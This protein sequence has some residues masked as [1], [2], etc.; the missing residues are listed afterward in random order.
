MNI[1]ALNTTNKL[2]EV[3]CS[4]NGKTSSSKMDGAFSEHIIPAIVDALER[5]D[6]TLEQIDCMGVVV[7]P[8]SFTGI[9]IG[10][11]VLKGIVCAEP[12]KCVQVNSF[13]LLA[14][15]IT[16][17]NFVVLLD[18]GNAEPYYAIFKNK[19]CT[20]YGFATLDKVQQYAHQ[21]GLKTYC[22]T[23]EKPSFEDAQGQFVESVCVDSKTLMGLVQSKARRG[24]FVGLNN[25]EPLYIKQSQAEVGL[26]NDIN[27][28]VAYRIATV[29]D[30]NALAT[31]D[32]Q[33]FEGSEQYD[34]QTFEEEL[35]FDDRHYV[36]ATHKNLVVAYVGLW[37][38]GDDLNLLKIAVL[39]QFRR[40]GIAKNLLQRAMEYRSQKKLDKFFLEVRKSNHKAI[41][42]YKK[43]GFDVVHTRHKYYDDGEDCLIMFDKQVK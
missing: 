33:I 1:L 27:Q 43:F 6:C 41:E 38:T 19:V 22:S 20:E 9:R 21:N 10:M 26:V 34:K 12:K 16:D 15:N 18:S 8:G 37:Q 42:L 24:E 32:E 14:Y 29:R 17:N 5:A 36:V 35:N 28:N 4:A 13:E 7:G 25:I 2:A 23:A 31:I 11:A 3:V 40:L 39:P 30:A